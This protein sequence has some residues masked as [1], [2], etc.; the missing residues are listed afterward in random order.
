[1]NKELENP[2]QE[3]FETIIKNTL[4]DAILFNRMCY[5]LNKTLNRGNEGSLF[6]IETEFKGLETIFS[7]INIS[8]DSPV[9]D[10]SFSSFLDEVEN[11]AEEK[12]AAEKLFRELTDLI[13][14]CGT[15]IKFYS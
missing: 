8:E 6:E 5:N 2:P 13:Q 7:I 11:E 4:H 1:M 9:R 10:L 14:K 3:V 12:H 15:G